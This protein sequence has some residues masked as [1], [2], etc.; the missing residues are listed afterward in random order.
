MALASQASTPTT[1]A[2]D[3]DTR[4]SLHGYEGELA[5]PHRPMPFEHM[6]GAQATVTGAAL[7]V[8]CSVD[9][10]LEVTSRDAAGV[11]AV[12][13]TGTLVAGALQA[14]AAGLNLNVASFAVDPTLTYAV[15]LGFPTVPSAAVAG[16]FDFV[17]GPADGEAL[18][19]TVTSTLV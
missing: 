10:P 12:V 14:D 16:A 6:A 11:T 8:A 13:Q 17:G 18:M 1:G 15:V 5:Q 3:T 19:V 9:L 7:A 2:A 4:T